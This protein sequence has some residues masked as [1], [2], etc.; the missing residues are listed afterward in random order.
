MSSII[1]DVRKHNGK[2][3][4]AGTDILAKEVYDLIGQGMSDADILKQF[5]PHLKQSDLD[6]VRKFAST[7][8]VETG[9]RSYRN[10]KGPN[11]S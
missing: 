1:V 3:Y 5:V 8:N 4:F 9:E 11:A 2:P 10:W 7:R 6:T